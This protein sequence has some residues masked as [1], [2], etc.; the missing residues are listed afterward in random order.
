MKPSWSFA[1]DRGGTFTDVVARAPGGGL[2]T[3]KLLS[4]NPG[5][6]EDAA[7]AGI[8]AILVQAGESLAT[9]SISSV[10]RAPSLS[11]TGALLRT[12]SSPPPSTTAA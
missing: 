8:E 6:Y 3:H 2:V 9:A 12:W 5:R 7:T 1:I 11:P 4:E 10:K